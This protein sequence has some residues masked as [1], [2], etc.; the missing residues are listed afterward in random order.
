M[1]SIN[2]NM[3]DGRPDASCR[4]W[5]LP[6][7]G[8]PLSKF[9]LPLFVLAEGRYRPIGTALWVGP[10]V[11]FLLTAMH[12]ITEAFRF[13][14]KLERM[15]VQGDLPPSVTLNRASL[16]VLHQG[17]TSES[18][19]KFSLIPIQTVNGGPP[20]DV[21]FGHPLF[22]ANR[23]V[24]SLPLSFAPPRI[25][26]TVWAVGYTGFE[27]RE[28]IPEEDVA[29][30]SFDW[31]RD[32]RHRFLAT[33]GSVQHIF[34]QRFDRGYCRGACF[35]FDNCLAHGQSGGPVI[36]DSGAVVG[37]NSC[38]VSLRFPSAM[39]LG[40]M[41]YPLLLTGIQFGATLGGGNFKLNLNATRPLFEL[42]ME[43]VISSDGSAEH[44]AFHKLEDGAGYG[45]GPCIPIAD[46]HGVF[47]D[48]QAFQ[49]GRQSKPMM[50]E[51]FRLRRTEE[52]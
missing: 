6:S 33:Q 44:V 51:A 12:N 23:P 36:S 46:K 11:Q 43:G 4:E 17:S 10:K 50:G 30:G 27:P 52:S 24:L 8:H 18:E 9:V 45:V 20:G 2:I 29:N 26:Q 15:F 37:I 32:Y 38:D 47:E 41:L 5:E 19:H 25:G 42:V 14:P 3:F 49:D 28:G 31:N 13:E 22:E 34:T 48:F 39:S 35:S 21:A 7:F 16:W 1:P 40:S